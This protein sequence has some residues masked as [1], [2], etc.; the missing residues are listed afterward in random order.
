MH[1][2][3]ARLHQGTRLCKE[4][5]HLELGILAKH[6]PAMQREERLRDREEVD[7]VSK[8]A[9]GRRGEKQYQPNQ[10]Q[11]PRMYTV[12]WKLYSTRHLLIAW[13][14]K[15]NNTDAARKARK[16]SD[17]IQYLCPF[18]IYFFLLGFYFILYSCDSSLGKHCYEAAPPLVH[19]T[20]AQQRVPSLCGAK[21]HGTYIPWVRRANNLALPGP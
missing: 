7:I 16:S 13:H 1:P 10:K 20:V 19:I 6:L 11:F 21:I 4:D 18:P 5:L 8:L 12:K 15:R 9:D 17:R 14:A 3:R 2:C